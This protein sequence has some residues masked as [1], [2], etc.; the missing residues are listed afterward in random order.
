MTRVQTPRVNFEIFFNN[1]CK[2]IILQNSGRIRRSAYKFPFSEIRA[3][4]ISVF[5]GK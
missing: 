2:I 5:D 1:Y 3:T 4:Q